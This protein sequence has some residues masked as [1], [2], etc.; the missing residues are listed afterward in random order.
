MVRA[1]DWALE[2]YSWLCYLNWIKTFKDKLWANTS[3][4][5]PYRGKQV[6]F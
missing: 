5:A 3:Y 2:F 4:W 1:G 6:E